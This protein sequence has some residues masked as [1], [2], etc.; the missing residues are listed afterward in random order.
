MS[1]ISQDAGATTDSE[2]AAPPLPNDAAFPQES[3]RERLLDYLRGPLALLPMVLLSF[4][5]TVYQGVGQWG[6]RQ[7]L[8]GQYGDRRQPVSDQRVCASREP[9]RG[10]LSEPGLRGSGS[11]QRGPD[12]RRR[13]AGGD[14][15][16][17]A[18][19]VLALTMT[20]CP[21]MRWSSSR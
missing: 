12:Y 19:C 14:R 16:R 5:I 2:S 6:S 4:I 21:P 9:Q 8:G 7:I 18:L 11:P 20:C 10:Q 1:L 13:Y 15:Q 17:G 3:A